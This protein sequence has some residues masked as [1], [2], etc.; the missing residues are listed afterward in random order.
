[1]V[2]GLNSQMFDF[3]ETSAMKISHFKPLTGA[4]KASFN[5]QILWNTYGMFKRVDWVCSTAQQL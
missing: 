1:M 5:V 3:P 2:H 4:I